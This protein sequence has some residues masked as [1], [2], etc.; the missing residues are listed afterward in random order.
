MFIPENPGE[1]WAL[2]ERITQA[3][4]ASRASR[5]TTYGRL[6]AFYLYGTDT[7]NIDGTINLIFPHIDQLLSFIYSNETTKFST[8]IGASVDRM[9]LKRVPILNQAV[10]DNWHAS[11]GDILFEMALE[12]AHVYGS[13]IFKTRWQDGQVEPN[14]VDPHDF[15]VLRED[16]PQVSRQEA[17]AQQYWVTKGELETLLTAA[18]HPRTSEI[19]SNVTAAP[20]NNL[21]QSNMVSNLV[22]SSQLPASGSGL[23]IGS[24]QNSLA[25][26]AMY[27][28]RVAEDMVRMTELYVYDSR[29]M[30]F[31]IITLASPYVVIFDREINRVFVDK[32][33]PFTQVCPIPQRDYFWGRSE[34]AGLIPLQMKYN[35]RWDQIERM[36]DK[37]ASPPTSLSG[38]PGINDEMKLAL[39]SP[40]GYIVN[41]NPTAKV[42]RLDPKIPDDLF[43]ELDRIEAAIDARIGLTNVTQGKGEAGVRSTGHANQLARLG[44]SRVK[45]RALTVEDSL[46]KVATMYLQMMQKYDGE[47][48][49]RDTDNHE[50]VANTFTKDYVVK[51][52]AHSNSPIFVED[53][54]DKGQVLFKNK[55]I[56]GERLIES[57]A[58]P[59]EQVLIDE[60]RTEV[61]PA[62]EKQRKEEM[63]LKVLEIR[64]KHPPAH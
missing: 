54:Q 50:F 14:C 37:Q 27:V 32:E 47:H 23:A 4:F 44:S 1:R 62:Q 24:F 39:D 60:Y 52:D 21:G 56:K 53:L 43:K 29:S 59:Q 19:M 12:W 51:V 2:Y 36:M 25:T 31:R 17:F 57:M 8:S 3:C 34:V 16:T 22:I 46:E 49:Y 55:L 7:G 41:D 11:N 42:E 61:Q 5:I 35:Q 15:G 9:Q 30:D 58:M 38:F 26:P 13:E 64:G 63:E 45:K 20:K 48:S 18:E 40:A 6:R 33:V 28:P 10:N